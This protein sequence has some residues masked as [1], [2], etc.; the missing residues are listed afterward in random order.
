MLCKI[1]VFVQK[2]LRNT[3]KILKHKILSVPQTVS[4]GEY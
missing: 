3:G 1:Q 2:A 4:I